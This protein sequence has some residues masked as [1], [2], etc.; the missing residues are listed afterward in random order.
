MVIKGGENVFPREVEEILGPVPG[1][2]DVFCHG[3]NENDEIFADL[4]LYVVREDNEAGKNLTEDML[5]EYV[6][7]TLA[8]HSTPDRVF[9]VDSLPR[10]AIGK[11]VPREVKAM[12]E[13]LNLD[14]Q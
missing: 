8:E 1:I 3:S 2:A 11:V 14:A 9:F 5:R 13:R 12:H 4:F 7:E 10:N 6:R